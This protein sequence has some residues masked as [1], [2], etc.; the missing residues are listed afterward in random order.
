V[1]Q[2][3]QKNRRILVIDDNK[4]IH[5][6]FR[7][8]LEVGGAKT[9]TLDEAKVAILG[10][11]AKASERE[12]FE[13]DSA[14]Q[15]AEGLQKVKEALAQ[16]KPYAMAFVDVRMPPG[17]D[18][19]ETI[20]RIW[21]EY[22]E[23][24]VVICTAYSDYQW[25]EI[26]DK[27]G[28]SD[29]LLIL[30]K[31]F[32]N[33]EARQLACALTEKWSLGRQT[34]LKQKDLEDAVAERTSEL[35]KTNKQLE[36]ETA[37][38]NDMAAQAET[39]NQAKSRFL[40][41]MSHEIRTPMNG[42]IGMIDLALDESVTDKVRDY[43]LTSR[44]SANTLLD[45]INDIL[46]LSKIEA[47]KLDVEIID[48]SLNKILA[49]IDSLIYPCI[50]E[51]GFDFA[52]LFPTPV[53]ESIRSDPTRLRQCLLNLVGNAAKFTDSGHVYV[54]VSVQA[55]DDGS[56]I[57][58]DVEDT[59]IG[60]VADR[61]KAIFEA[62]G[63]A[64]GSTSRRFGGTGLGLTIT[65]RLAGL[66]GGELSVTSEPGK[67]STFSLIIPAGVDVESQPLIT[68]LNKSAPT[69]KW[70]SPK[71]T[72][73]GSILVAEDN[74]VNQKV[75]LTMLEKVGLQVTIVGDGCEAVKKATSH[76]Y[77][78]I[79]MDV[80]MPNMNGLEATQSLRS[81]GLNIPIIALTASIM[82]EDIDKALA[83]GFDEYLPKPINRGEFLGV[84]G[85]YLS[86]H[87]TSLTGKI[88]SLKSQCDELVQV[89]SGQK[90]L[91]ADPS[92]PAAEHNIEVP[93]DW[94]AMMNNL[95]DE[96]MVMD[97]VR[98]F[99]E[100]SGQTVQKLAEVINAKIPEDVQLHAHSLKGMS[101]MIGAEELRKKA[102]RLECAGEE[103][104]TEAFDLLF[105]DIKKDFDKLV[106][107]LS[108]RDWVETAKQQD[109][110]KQQAGQT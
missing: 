33:V 106:K 11:A 58:F 31:P 85:K 101:A 87:D 47:D 61:Q 27:L 72:L 65:K 39:A 26:V 74:L 73:S 15:G 95:G 46:D 19:I 40:A 89:A 20:G 54:R 6:D 78:L 77:D 92:V 45:I 32:D 109:N 88:D 108:E 4:S 48:C 10:D 63:Q 71:T 44:S 7:E 23:L 37:R 97:A 84:L 17:W 69:Q 30:K 28:Q 38:A 110:K 76:Q 50:N 75:I 9:G 103:G 13:I 18:G 79:V 62:F 16:G 91:Q 107:F 34:K 2:K 1:K 53:P 66:L 55:G 12:G 70:D 68:G 43:L 99:S 98:I 93:V 51:K 80:R 94:S 56:N 29:Q 81:S 52:V 21:A 102:S 14:F 49:D 22:P 100:D 96:D 105:D 41:N 82:K 5:K 59:G 25:S 42:I 36:Q 67:G 57:R 24:E 86:S 64:D 8:I 90:S 60:I 104:D 83:A 35:S 3:Q